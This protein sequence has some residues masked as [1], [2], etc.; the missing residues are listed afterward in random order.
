MSIAPVAEAARYCLR[1]MGRK[2]WKP[3]ERSFDLFVAYCVTP[4]ATPHWR[5]S[6]REH[7][8]GPCIP[9]RPKKCIA[10]GRTHI[11]SEDCGAERPETTFRNSMPRRHD[12][13]TLQRAANMGCFADSD[14]WE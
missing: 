9:S 13:Y 3:H 12:G 6:F 2:R 8:R 10:C 11:T 1:G 4:P 5:P 14:N 7:L